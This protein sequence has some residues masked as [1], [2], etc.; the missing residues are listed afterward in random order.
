MTEY[1]ADLLFRPRKLNRYKTVNIFKVFLV[2]AVLGLISV[3]P[4]IIDTIQFMGL[5]ESD[6][7]IIEQIYNVN[8]SN[9]AETLPDCVVDNEQLICDNL[10]EAVSIGSFSTIMGRFTV[11]VDPTGEYRPTDTQT[12]LVLGEQGIYYTTMF[13]RFIIPFGSLPSKWQ[14][15]NFTTIREADYPGTALYDYFIGGLN[16][17]LIQLKPIIIVMTIIWHII[18]T[19]VWTLFL[20]FLFFLFFRQFRFG[21]VFRIC[22]YAQIL[23]TII[24]LM[25]NLA[26]LTWLSFIVMILTMVYMYLALNPIERKVLE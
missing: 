7:H 17:V 12:Y 24:L 13:G 16:E 14:H 8:F 3:V 4:S 18:G 22:A 6:R 19:L 5:G 26:N 23:P 25:L 1:L 11:V 2:I 9:I 21:S 20:S 10:E 15:V